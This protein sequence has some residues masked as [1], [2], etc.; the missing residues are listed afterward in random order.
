[1]QTAYKVYVGI[2]EKRLKVEVESK[3]LLPDSQA[4]FRE[5][6]GTIDN[7]YA[8]NYLINREVGKDKGKML[9][10]FVDFKSAFD[11][12]DRSELSVA[13]RKRGVSEGLVRRYEVVLSETCER[14]RIG[15]ELGERFWTEKGV[16]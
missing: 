10:L 7:I 3:G 5:R 1:M 14:V 12:V 13:M 11:T 4:G 16:R 15:K 2:L 8:L 9:V 6:R